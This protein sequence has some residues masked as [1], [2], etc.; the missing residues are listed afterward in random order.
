MDRWATVFICVSNGD[1]KFPAG[2]EPQNVDIKSC[3][4][5]VTLPT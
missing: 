4:K 5:A 2:T 1:S 3:E